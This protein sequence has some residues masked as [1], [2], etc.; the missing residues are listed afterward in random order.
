MANKGPTDSDR[1]EKE[2]RKQFKALTNDI[3]NEG[4]GW[5][6]KK[7]GKSRIRKRRIKKEKKK[8]TESKE[9]TVEMEK[10]DRKED[11]KERLVVGCENNGTYK[12]GI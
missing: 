4:E 7:E 3:Y 9:K 10:K 2:G 8:K 11:Q 12:P 5:N 1:K 6:G